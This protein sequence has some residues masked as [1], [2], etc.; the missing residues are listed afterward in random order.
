M[1]KTALFIN[2]RRAKLVK[3]DSKIL[4][5]CKNKKVLDVGCVGQDINYDSDN[6][7]HQRISKVA[8]SLIGVDIDQAGIDSIKKKNFN[9]LPFAQLKETSL[10][11]ETI[12]MADVIEHV[13]DP[14]DFLYSYS[15]F[16]DDSGL[17][18]VTTPNSNRGINFINIFLSNNYNI[19]LEH[20]MWL[21][22]KTFAEIA[23]RAE[24]EI[25]QFYWLNQYYDFKSLKVLNKIKFALANL[26]SRYRSNFSHNFMFLL[27][28]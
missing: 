17:I 26:L 20:T 23:T 28:K 5:L 9:A 11:F 15:K 22:P 7:L 12:I 8:Y 18:V 2:Y 13:N 10:K 16:L 19:N 6:W 1:D 24:L 27:T 4:E 14:V 21:C 25:A 3:K